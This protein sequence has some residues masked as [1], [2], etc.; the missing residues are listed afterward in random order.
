MVIEADLVLDF[1]TCLVAYQ[2]I[3]ILYQLSFGFAS[4]ENFHFK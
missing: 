2:N 1:G 4:P 3:K